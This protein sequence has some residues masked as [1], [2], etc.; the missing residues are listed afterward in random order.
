MDSPRLYSV[1]TSRRLK[2]GSSLSR[3]LL[4]PALGQGVG[5]IGNFTGSLALD[6][7]SMRPEG[8]YV[9]AIAVDTF[10]I[11]GAYPVIFARNLGM[12]R[13][14]RQKRKCES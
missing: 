13:G 12:D 6:R 9:L 1:S 2:G 11:V 14:R 5:A 7:R 10:L 8:R 4:M 3:L